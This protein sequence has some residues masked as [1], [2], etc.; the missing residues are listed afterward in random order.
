MWMK[1]RKVTLLDLGAAAQEYLR[2]TDAR[3]YISMTDVCGAYCTHYLRI[4]VV[5]RI[6][7]YKR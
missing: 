3:T 4:L 5:D 7:L 6:E 1:A 2:A